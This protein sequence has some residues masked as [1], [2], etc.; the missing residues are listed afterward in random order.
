MVRY[1]PLSGMWTNRVF[2]FIKSQNLSDDENV[3]N[4][5]EFIMGASKYKDL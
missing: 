2:K 5:K 4:F 1:C 3:I